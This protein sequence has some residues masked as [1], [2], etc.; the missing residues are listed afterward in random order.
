MIFLKIFS[1]KAPSCGSF[2]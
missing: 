1:T 2:F